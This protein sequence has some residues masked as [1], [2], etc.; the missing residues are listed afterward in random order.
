[1]RYDTALEV[2]DESYWAVILAGG[3]GAR[4]RPL[5]HA[6]SGDDRPKQFVRLIGNETLLQQTIHRV[7]RLVPP[8]RA[9]VVLTRNHENF[10]TE[11]PA[12]AFAIV[13]PENR[14]TAPAILYSLLSIANSDPHAKVALFPVDHHFSDDTT[15]IE[16]V[17][18]AFRAVEQQ[19]D[20][21]V[22]LGAVP[23][24]P[25]VDYGWIQPGEPVCCVAEGPLFRVRRFWEKPT[26]GLAEQ[27]F[28][29]GC[30][31]NTFVLVSEVSRLLRLIRSAMPELCGQ[32][33][34]V[35]PLIGT[36]REGPAMREIYSRLSATDF[37]RDVLSIRPR[38]LT[39]LPVEGS[40]WVDMGTTDRVRAVL[41]SQQM[42]A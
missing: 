41:A 39:V 21:I 20:L 38:A 2:P 34:A 6:I 23:T 16:H 31:W 1:M 35:Q 7:E 11:M 27:L 8:E 17:A 9:K 37:S 25:E 42:S 36:R 5:T 29:E 28:H 32:F 18:I 24:S 13:Q 14:G 4:L 33:E 26:R 30:L 40:R 22:L 10:F 19:P 3:D 15:F 12:S